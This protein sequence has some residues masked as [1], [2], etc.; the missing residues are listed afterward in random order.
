METKK[1]ILPSE[2]IS[3]TNG[4]ASLKVR[5]PDFDGSFLS[6]HLGSEKETSVF[7]DRPQEGSLMLQEFWEDAS[8]KIYLDISP[9]GDLIAV[10]PDGY[11]G[12]INEQGEL[13]IVQG[14]VE[15]VKQGIGVM[16]VGSTFVVG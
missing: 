14:S 7:L 16:V 15:E 10:F 1:A 11:D 6:L 5:V 8:K 9:Q 12:F 2:L 13:I 4:R 3:G